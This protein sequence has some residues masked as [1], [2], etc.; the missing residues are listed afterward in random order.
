M[1]DQEIIEAFHVM[2]DNFPEP[3][4]I[5]QKT[6]EMIAVNKKAAELGLTAGVKCS[7]IG[8][9]E[10]HRGCL[11][12]KAIDT[13]QA[14]AVKYLGPSSETLYG[15]WIPIP[16]RPEWIIHF[17]VGRMPIYEELKR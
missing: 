2:W 17:G 9:P 1:T 15:Y 16:E 13:K 6:R 14:I 5:T 12:N 4:T 8:K 10:D 11:C 3:V 7:S